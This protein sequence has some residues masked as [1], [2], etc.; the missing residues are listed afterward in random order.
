M[1]GKA[2]VIDPFMGTGSTL[3]AARSLGLSCI[4]SDKDSRAAIAVKLL[5]TNTETGAHTR[6]NKQGVGSAW[7]DT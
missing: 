6:H 5:M 7:G 3:V 1:Q 4:G 2:L